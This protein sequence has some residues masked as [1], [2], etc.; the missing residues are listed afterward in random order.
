VVG[1]GMLRHR[2]AEFIRFLRLIG[3][4][5]PA[6]RNLPLILDNHAPTK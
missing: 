2:A 6:G 5:I 3:R 1:Q 4:Q